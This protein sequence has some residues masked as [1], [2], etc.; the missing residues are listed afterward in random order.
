MTVHNYKSR[1]VHK[2]SNGLN[3]SSSF[4]DVFHKVWTQF[5]LWQI[6]QV[7]GPWASPYR[8]NGQMTMTVHNYVGLDN[9]TELLFEKICHAVT[10]IWVP[11]VWQPPARPGARPAART[12]TTIPIEPRGMRGKNAPD[13]AHRTLRLLAGLVLLLYYEAHLHGRPLISV[14]W[15]VCCL[16]STTAWNWRINRKKSRKYLFTEIPPRPCTY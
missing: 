3:P 2:T 9:S 5:Y 14:T 7:L 4:R 11:Q 6:W 16:W 15:R 1:Q 13:I 8:A 10:E 12:V